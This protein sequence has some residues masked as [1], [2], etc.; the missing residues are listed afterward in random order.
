MFDRWAKT[1][2]KEEKHLKIPFSLWHNRMDTLTWWRET[3]LLFPDVPPLHSGR[4]VSRCTGTISGMNF[5]NPAPSG[6]AKRIPTRPGHCGGP[7]GSVFNPLTSDNIP[8]VVLLMISRCFSNF[9]QIKFKNCYFFLNSIIEGK[10]RKTN[11]RDEAGPRLSWW[12]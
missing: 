3:N 5:V 6:R 4:R 8:V 12:F 2:S 10:T 1:K 11:G 7:Q 9:F